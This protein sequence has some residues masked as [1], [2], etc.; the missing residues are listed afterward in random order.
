MDVGKRQGDVVQRVK[1]IEKRVFVDREAARRLGFAGEDVSANLT[2]EAGAVER[3]TAGEFA[4]FFR[5]GSAHVAGSFS[6][7]RRIVKCF[8]KFKDAAIFQG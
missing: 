1:K 7:A 5:A 2:G 3:R 6:H 8:G 4:G